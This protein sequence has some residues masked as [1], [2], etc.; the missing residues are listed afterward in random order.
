MWYQLTNGE[1]WL[2][3]NT[4][5]L[6]IVEIIIPCIETR[7]FQKKERETIMLANFDESL[8]YAAPGVVKTRH[9]T[10]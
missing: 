7:I 10:G 2:V 3:K 5:S 1:G 6:H 8:P 4:P 9:G